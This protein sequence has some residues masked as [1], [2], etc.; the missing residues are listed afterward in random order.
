MT[1]DELQ[2]AWA[3][4]AVLDEAEVGRDSLGAA[5]LHAKWLKYLTDE[6]L[7]AIAA[8]NNYKKLY[9]QK[10]T[11]YAGTMSED[12]RKQ[13]GWDNNP[14]KILRTDI[15]VYLDGDTEL[16]EAKLKLAYA[17]TK[18]KFLEGVMKHIY[19][20]SYLL[21]NAIEWNKFIAGR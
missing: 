10:F 6:S 3:N 19:N 17:E 12:E 1:L 18:V 7:L 15:A 11:W 8:Q 5:R 21:N 9:R 4:D 20:R 16:S 13:L 2:T 14:L